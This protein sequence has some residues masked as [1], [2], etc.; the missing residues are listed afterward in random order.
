MTP[1][2]LTFLLLLLTGAVLLAAGCTGQSSSTNSV[3]VSGPVKTIQ[4]ESSIQ[5]SSTLNYSPFVPKVYATTGN[6]NV[7]HPLSLDKYVLIEHTISINGKTIS[8]SCS[9]AIYFD[10]YMNYDFDVQ[11]GALVT[12]LPVYE[13]VNSSLILFYAIRK[14]ENDSQRGGG[15]REALPVYGLPHR[16]YDNVSFE[17]VTPD[18]TVT[19]RYGNSVAVLKSKESWVASTSR[20]TEYR[21]WE[22]NTIYCTEELVTNDT[23]SNVG[24]FEKNKIN[25]IYFSE[26]GREIIF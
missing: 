12:T 15:G 1:R 23:F 3:Q 24:L 16:T 11:E 8:G 5:T 6:G 13:P 9:P 22:K 20:K 19:L 18:G 14:S 21:Y 26:S 17:S 25:V 4:P 10:G 2:R 7:A